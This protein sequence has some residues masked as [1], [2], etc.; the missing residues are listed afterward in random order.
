MN[1]AEH[2]WNEK[3]LKLTMKIRDERPEL[4]DYINEMPVTNPDAQDP[5]IRL[6]NLKHYYDSLYNLL[7]K[8][9]IEPKS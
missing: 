8:Y 9:K 4:S 5:E 6:N 1:N 2:E 3:I 7:E